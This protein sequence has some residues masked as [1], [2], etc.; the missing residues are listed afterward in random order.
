MRQT[1]ELRKTIEFHHSISF[2]NKQGDDYFRL[3]RADT[4]QYFRY[5]KIWEQKIQKYF[6]TLKKKKI[7]IIHVDICGRT[8]AKNLGADKSYC[9]SLKTS[10]IK[11]AFAD[12]NQVFID[13]DLFNTEEF[14]ILIKSIKEEQPA[15]GTF[16][17][18]AGLQSYYK[19]KVEDIPHYSNI[20]YEILGHR[21]RKII[22][23]IRPG[24][25]IYMERPFQFDVDYGADCFSNKLPENYTISLKIKDVIKSLN[26]DIEI[27]KN[28]E[29]IYFL[30][31][32]RI[33][34]AKK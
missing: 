21:L 7:P 3:D 19:V 11:R 23:V 5:H 17:P 1:N 12:K 18:V 29:G 32:K 33:R 8:N 4:S 10:Q 16:E 25:Y 28:I 20:T 15:L 34:A 14:N 9:F 27:D 24:G 31:R 2:I 6:Q 13:G 22:S 26:C 30:I